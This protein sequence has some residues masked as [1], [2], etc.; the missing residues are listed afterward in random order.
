M[1]FI[2]FIVFLFVTI[3]V[4][5]QAIPNNIQ[6]LITGLE[7]KKQ[8]AV[9]D[10][11]AMSYKKSDPKLFKHYTKTALQIAKANN[12]NGALHFFVSLNR[13]YRGNGDFDS[14]IIYIDSAI[15]FAFA[16][17][18]NKMYGEMY[19]HKGLTYMRM[20]SYEK[21]TEDFFTSIKYSEAINDSSGLRDAFDHLGSVNF[22]RKDHKSAVK[23][24]KK[25]LIYSLSEKKIDL[26]VSTL[27]NIGLAFSNLHMFDSALFYQKKAVTIIEQLNDSS[28][29]AESYIN[30]GSTLMSLKKIKE[31]ELYFAKAYEITTKLNDDYALQLTTLYMG[32][33][34]LMSGQFNKAQPFLERSFVLSKKINIPSQVK[35]A[36]LTLTNLYDTI[37]DYKRSSFYYREVVNIMDETMADEN[38]RA[39]NELSAKYETEKKQQEIQFL[40]QDKQLKENKIEKDRYVKLFI[41][42]VAGLLLLLSIIF[43]YRFREK[44]KDNS[45]LASQKEEIEEQKEELQHKNKEITDSINYA[46]RIQGSVLPS[47]KLAKNLFPDSFIYFQPKDIVSGDF[48]WIAQNNDHAYLAVADCTGHGVPGAMM[49]MLGNSLLNQIVLNAKI[50][51]PDV[52]LKELHFHVVRTLNENIQQR[53]S[54]DGMDIALVR[55]DIKNKQ[56]LYAGAG[57]PLYI[58]KNNLLEIYKA[59]KYSIGGI[60]DT[61]EVNY[62]L[63]EIKIDSPTQFYMFTDGVPD[64]FGGPK[65]KKFMSKQLQ[66]LIAETASLAVNEQ[67]QRFKA[68]FESWKSKVEQTD[69]VTLISI[70]LA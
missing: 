10:S 7:T 18:L 25:A 36:A 9:L 16:N 48:Y 66:E 39:I 51:S 42:I 33:V 55:I 40:T 17:K 45:L 46:K 50:N 57:R 14:A 15:Q 70:R 8:L 20:G 11:V 41:G 28:F 26:Y 56:V 54:K 32:K 67:E 30:I 27:D 13:F 64:Q 22:Y 63:H 4:N 47:I 19:D 31:A 1:R 43:I 35:E 34:Y 52:I 38:T 3:F 12:K 5:G 2:L 37:G 61:Q 59:D 53:D 68:V 23:F 60:Y 44:K 58:I 21:A 49:S 29:L 69:D 62:V 6:K 65:G 24:Y